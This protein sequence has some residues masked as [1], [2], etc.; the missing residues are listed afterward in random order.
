MTEDGGGGRRGRE[1]HGKGAP[2]C[3]KW[4]RVDECYAIHFSFWGEGA[5]KV[6]R[7]CIIIVNLRPKYPIL[8][9]GILV[10]PLFF[11]SNT[12]K[13]AVYHFKK[14]EAAP[15]LLTVI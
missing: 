8:L 5:E 12:F 9:S 4:R 13:S 3:L 15:N 6:L 1:R 7:D 11:F 10:H 2:D 14:S